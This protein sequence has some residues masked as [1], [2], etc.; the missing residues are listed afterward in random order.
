MSK[1]L[2]IL[3]LNCSP[4]ENSNS[5]AVTDDAFTALKNK[6]D[7]VE[8]EI[9]T[10]KD[11]NIKACRACDVCGKTRDTG[12]YFACVIKDD[13]VPGIIEKMTEADGYFVATPVYFGLATDL[14]S[15]FIMR[16][17]TPRHQDFAL[18]NKVVGIA[19]IAGRRSGGAE[20]TITSSWL[21]FIRNGC[22]IVGNGDK[23]CQFGAMGWA[24]PR[25]QILT[26]DWG[27]EQSRDLAERIYNVAKLISVG[28]D[29]LCYKDSM[30]FSYSAGTRK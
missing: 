6:F 3:G 8:T 23:T 30:N 14:F 4:R 11:F 25:G 28:T 20:T 13:D 1:T 19:A 21:P 2:K 7:D 15:K 5:Y 18:A 24:G 17:R 9:I 29:T 10:L 22:L 27:V 16:L 26:D 12:E